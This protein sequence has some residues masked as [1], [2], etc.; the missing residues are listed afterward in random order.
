MK[1]LNNYVDAFVITE[2]TTTFSGLPKKMFFEEASHE[3]SEFK[4]KIHYQVVDNVPNLSPFERDWF[5]RDQAMNIIKNNFHDSDILIYGDVDEIPNPSGVIFAQQ[6]LS[7][8]TPI[9]HLAQDLFYYFMNLKEVSGTLLSYAGEYEQI[10]K[11]HRKWLGSV[12]T[13][14]GFAKKDTLTS[15]RNPEHRSHGIRVANGGWHFSYMG[16][17]KSLN[18]EERIVNKIVSAAHQ[19]LNTQEI[20]SNAAQQISNGKDVFKRRKSK[21]ELQADLSYLPVE[22]LLS[23]EELSHLIRR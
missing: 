21:F 8:S 1:V 10:K 12:V 11:N 18:S 4:Q 15:L 23:I 7:I 20:R 6:N 9:A 3:F 16:G 19:E 13:T 14:V 2:A 5:Q 22:A 17:D